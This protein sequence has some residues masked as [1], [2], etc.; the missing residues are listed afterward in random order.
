M[1][2]QPAC[3]H[4]KCDEIDLYAVGGTDE[5]ARPFIHEVRLQGPRG[6]VVRVQVTFDD[7]AMICAM[8]T[9][10]F[11]QVRHRLRAWKPS[12]C[13]LRMANG[14]VARSEAIWSGTV[15]LDGVRTTG[16][17]KVFDSAGGWSFLLGKPMLQLFQAHH[18]YECDVIQV[19]DTTR[20]AVLT[21]QIDNPYYAHRAS[22]G[23]SAAAD[24]K[25]PAKRHSQAAAVTTIMGSGGRQGADEPMP[26]RQVEPFHPKRVEEVWKAIR[27]GTD[28]TMS[29]QE[30]VR[31]LVQAY[32]D[33]FAL[34]VR[35]VVLAKDATLH[36]EIPTDAR[37]PTKTC[38]HTFMPPQR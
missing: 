27:I 15:E 3:M 23:L 12:T 11:E 10:I 24:W 16:A 5:A 18:N 26:K 31:E 38:Q 8:S 28:L 20:R 25:Q 35:E 9:S 29:Q 34:S 22:Q 17:F 1:D 7:G 32:A 37:L 19:S 36:L 33:C 14:T 21:N 4:G 2:T 13:V 6:E 30:Q